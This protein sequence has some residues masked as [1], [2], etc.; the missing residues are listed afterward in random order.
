MIQH[1]IKIVG[2]PQF[3]AYVESFPEITKKAAMMAI[4]DA[5]RK[6]RSH[7]K[8]EILKQV[9]FPAGYLGNEKGGRLQ[10]NNFATERS[11]MASIKGRFNPTSLVRFTTNQSTL[12]KKGSENGK[13][14]GRGKA[15]VQVKPG[16]TAII[17]KAYLMRLNNGNVGFAYRPGKGGMKN[18]EGAVPIGSGWYLLYGPSVNQVFNTVREDIAPTISNTLSSEFDRQFRRLS[19]GR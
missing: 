9:K 15:R 8:K 2:L 14:I 12:M 1:E 13:I 6:G 17:D 7:A 5:A 18:T 4:N 16:S 19:N 3:E 11:L 10:I